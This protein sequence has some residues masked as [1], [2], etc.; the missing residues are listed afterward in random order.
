[1]KSLITILVAAMTVI[2]APHAW[3]APEPEPLSIKL[4][5][6]KVVIV[7]GRE[8]Q[9]PADAAQPGDLLE[10]RAEYR[11]TGKTPTTQ[12]K[13]TVPVPA[14]GLEYLPGSASPPAVN[15]SVDGRRFA[16]TPLT[17]SVTLPDGRRETRPVPVAE[18]R[19]LQW[20]L[21]E[22]APGASAVV[23]ARMTV[24][25]TLAASPRNTPRGDTK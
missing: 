19:F 11:N 13:A 4:T 18:Y 15:A 14:Q 12:V 23:K 7:D 24:T 8:K 16:P 20:D 10:Y 22:L 17:R 25:Q 21:G 9:L 2:A 6:H 5:V 3:A 1:M